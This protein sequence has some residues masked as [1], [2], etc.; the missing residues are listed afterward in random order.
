MSP[1][2]SIILPTYDRLPLLREAVA[3]V[4]AQTVED[5]ELFVVDDGS[6]DGTVEWVASLGDSRIVAIPQ[7]H[8]GNRSRM[9]NLGAARA[10]AEWLAFLDSDDFWEPNKLEVQLGRLGTH[11]HCRWSCTGVRF[12]DG[13]GAPIAQRAGKPYE[14]HSG[15]ILEKLLTFRAAATM[16]TLMVHRSLF[17]E[18]GGFDEGFMLREDYEFELRLAQRSEIHALAESLTVV[19]H[20]SGRTSSSKRVA[21]LHRGTEMVYRKV[22]RTTSDP[23]IRAL[24]R[25]LCASQL[26]HQARALSKDGE[27]ALALAAVRRA[28]LDAPLAGD[29]WRSTASCLLRALRTARVTDSS[30]ER[31]A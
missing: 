11:P 21:D 24:C 30:T 12:I 10:R 22:G 29:V 14:A 17:D 28:L 20:H 1:A 2:V 7:E 27:H 31:V 4:L 26:S 9:R 8:T 25:R 13:V 23:R 19:R 6:T 5:W 3:S 15:W 18:V 16:P